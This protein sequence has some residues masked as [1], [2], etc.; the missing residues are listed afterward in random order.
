MDTARRRC[1][2]CAP[3][4]RILERAVPDSFAADRLLVVSSAEGFFQGWKEDPALF[5]SLE[6]SKV[7][8]TPEVM[9]EC[10]MNQR[11]GGG[12][13]PSPGN[14]SLRSTGPGAVGP[15]ARCAMLPSCSEYF[16]LASEK[17]GLLAYR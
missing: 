9:K 13:Y 7:R 16:L 8:W 14:G 17:H 11:A 1:C 12:F 5:E 3:A 10:R 15:R 6:N 2:L 4:S